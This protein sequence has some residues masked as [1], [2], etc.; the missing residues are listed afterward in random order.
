V[1]SFKN[2]KKGKK[3]EF[4]KKNVFTHKCT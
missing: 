2:N 1:I 4:T 3:Y